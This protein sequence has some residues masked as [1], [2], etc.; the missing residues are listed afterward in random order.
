[1]HQ[2]IATKNKKYYSIEHFILFHVLNKTMLGE[3]IKLK[4]VDPRLFT[5]TLHIGMCTYMFRSDFC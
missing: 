4:K 1:M 3:N 5:A 2:R